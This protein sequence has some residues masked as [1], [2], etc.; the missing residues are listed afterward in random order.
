MA[1]EVHREDVLKDYDWSAIEAIEK[2]LNFAEFGIWIDPIDGTAEY[3]SGRDKVTK[4]PNIKANGLECVTVLLGVYEIESGTPVMGVINQP[5][6]DKSKIHWGVSIDGLNANNIDPPVEHANTKTVLLS[7]SEDRKYI[8]Y[9]RDTLKYNLIFSSGAGHK[10]LKLIQG[11]AELFLVSKASTFLW[12]TC[13]PHAILR[14]L[15]GNLINLKET[16]DTKRAVE[17]NY[18]KASGKCNIGGV[19]GFRTQAQLLEFSKML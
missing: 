4:N 2:T 19:M 9:L 3:I 7:L 11:H 10:L 18:S 13:A 5:F 14:S 15:G 12:D 6:D 16:I 8:Y 17:L 1:Q